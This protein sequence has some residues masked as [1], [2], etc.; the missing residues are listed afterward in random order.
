MVRCGC[1]VLALTRSVAHTALSAIS[2]R[3]DTAIYVP[4]TRAINDR[5]AQEIFEKH[6]SFGGTIIGG[7][8]ADRWVD[9]LH[10]WLDK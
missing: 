5:D 6:Q 7:R 10:A 3:F 9:E 8:K 1:P 2:S 4:A